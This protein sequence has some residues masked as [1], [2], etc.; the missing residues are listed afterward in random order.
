VLNIGSASLQP[1]QIIDPDRNR[2]FATYGSPGR[3]I[4]VSVQGNGRGRGRCGRVE[5]TA[6]R[7]NRG[8]KGS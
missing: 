2:T 4:S 1:S 3:P 5:D 7:L 6:L 8:G